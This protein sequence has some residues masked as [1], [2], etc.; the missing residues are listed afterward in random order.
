MRL[1]STG[2]SRDPGQV[3]KPIAV[4]IQ[5]ARMLTGL[6][7]TT[8]WKLIGD[9]TLATVRVGRRRLILYTSIEALLEPHH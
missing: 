5:A 8:L 6:G 7:N 2:A 1:Q 4:T 9:G 3:G